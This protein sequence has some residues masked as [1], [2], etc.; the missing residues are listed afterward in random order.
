MS[1]Q[2]EANLELSH[3]IK[4]SGASYTTTEQQDNHISAPAEK[5]STNTKDQS[6][7]NPSQ[8]QMR[9][10]DPLDQNQNQNLIPTLTRT[11]QELGTLQ[12]LV[13]LFTKVYDFPKQKTHQELLNHYAKFPHLFRQDS[14]QQ[15]YMYYRH[16]QLNALALLHLVQN[17]PGLQCHKP[18]LLPLPRLILPNL[19]KLLLHQPQYH[20]PED[21]LLR[22]KYKLVFMQHS[23]E[24]KDLLEVIMEEEE[25]NQEVDQPP[26][27]PRFQYLQLPTFGPWEPYL[28]SSAETGPKPLTLWNSCWDISDPILE[29]LDLTP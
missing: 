7:M 6:T 8:D 10:Q 23:D 4:D 9:K 14:H 12:S 29:S 2:K 20:L 11:Q 15:T 16:Q 21:L 27:L 18:P 1:H 22:N 19:R 25:A 26:L 28:E 3:Y 13:N 24:M 17:N 5:T